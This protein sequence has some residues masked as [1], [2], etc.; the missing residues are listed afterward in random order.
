L[1]RYGATRD[2]I[3]PY[4]DGIHVCRASTCGE[5]VETLANIEGATIVHYE[6]LRDAYAVPDDDGS[7]EIMVDWMIAGIGHRDFA[8]R[9]DNLEALLKA[10]QRA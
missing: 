9:A 2:H 8:V 3:C 5:H 7:F 1:S 6:R 10:A 4:V